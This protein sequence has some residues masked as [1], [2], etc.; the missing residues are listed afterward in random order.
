MFGGVGRNG[1]IIL[2]CQPRGSARVR[3]GGGGGGW[4]CYAVGLAVGR[5]VS[6]MQRHTT[7]R[8]KLHVTVGPVASHGENV[9]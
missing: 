9:L 8:S 6:V 3:A 7:V 4:G 1:Q 5:A 2:V